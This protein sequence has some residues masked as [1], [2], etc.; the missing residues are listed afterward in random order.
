[1]QR[2][3]GLPKPASKIQVASPYPSCFASISTLSSGYGVTPSVLPLTLGC[4][5]RLQH[6]RFGWCLESACATER[7]TEVWQKFGLYFSNCSKPAPVLF[8]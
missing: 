4:A 1:M 6:D 2:C 7:L 3:H 5:W 8:S